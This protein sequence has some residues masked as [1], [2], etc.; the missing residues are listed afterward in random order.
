MLTW[1]LT[2]TWHSSLND[3]MPSQVRGNTAV[4]R[5][6]GLYVNTCPLVRLPTCA[7]PWMVLAA[8]K[9]E[10][11]KAFASTLVKLPRLECLEAEAG[12]IAVSL[13]TRKGHC[14]HP[15]TV[16]SGASLG[17]RSKRVLAAVG[18]SAP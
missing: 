6:G 3:E 8:A 4:M 2:L 1:H 12:N 14:N 18:P 9:C 17:L 11:E 15:V 7:S 5:G 10:I 16:T 13:P